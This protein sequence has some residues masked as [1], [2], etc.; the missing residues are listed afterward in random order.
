MS[1]EITEI[2]APAVPVVD[3]SAVA[4]QLAAALAR[5]VQIDDI[6]LLRMSAGQNL[7]P[8]GLP[9]NIKFESDAEFKLNEADSKIAVDVTFKLLASYNDSQL[10]EPSLM[11]AATFRVTYKISSLSGLSSFHYDAFSFM[12]GIYNAWPYWRE[13][14]HSSLSRMGLPPLQIPVFTTQNIASFYIN[15][16]RSTV[17]NTEKIEQVPRNV[18]AKPPSDKKEE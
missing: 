7:R 10:A 2:P 14:V 16:R 15:K 5:R 1:S 4:L 6:R 9:P 18:E 12:N 13:L 3:E 8:G 11:M 17:Q